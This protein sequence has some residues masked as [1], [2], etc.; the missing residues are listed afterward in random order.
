MKA[1]ST[2]QALS[3]IYMGAASFTAYDLVL[4]TEHSWAEVA[5][6]F[7]I[8]LALQIVEAVKKARGEA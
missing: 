8:V 6:M 2:L 4:S 5:V 3:L 7:G 1:H